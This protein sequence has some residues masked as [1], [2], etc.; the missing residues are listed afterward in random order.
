M[1]LGWDATLPGFRGFRETR[2]AGS[3][4]T[5]LGNGKGVEE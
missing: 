1:P 3:E 5:M 4:K 2:A